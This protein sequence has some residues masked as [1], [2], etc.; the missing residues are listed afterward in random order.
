MAE[1]REWIGLLGIPAP[2]R[3]RGRLLDGDV[4]RRET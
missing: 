2:I 3:G 4:G 1:E